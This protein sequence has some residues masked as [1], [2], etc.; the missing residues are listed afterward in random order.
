[1]QTLA[2]FAAVLAAA[3]ANPFA[4]YGFGSY[5][6]LVN[7]GIPTAHSYTFSRKTPTLAAVAAPVAAYAA[8]LAVAAPVLSSYAVNTHIAAPLAAPAIAYNGLGLA[9]GAGLYGAGL[10]GKA[11]L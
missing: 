8:P 6:G 7:Y 9:H 5:K 4:A 3:S 10:Y 11:L 2:I 1:M